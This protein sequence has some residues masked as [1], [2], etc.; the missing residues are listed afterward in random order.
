MTERALVLGGYAAVF[1]FFLS[2]RFHKYLKSMK[3]VK[4]KNFATPR[5]KNTSLPLAQ[6]RAYS[7]LLSNSTFT[8]VGSLKISWTG[9]FASVRLHAASTSSFLA[10]EE[11]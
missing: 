9:Q 3:R 11:T 8:G 2:V 1:V 6:A 7:V 5:A 4:I 10:F